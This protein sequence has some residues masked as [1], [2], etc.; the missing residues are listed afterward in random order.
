MV[1][2]FHLERKSQLTG[3]LLWRA[4]LTAY[5]AWQHDRRWGRTIDELQHETTGGRG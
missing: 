2:L 4:N 5:N 1:R 3:A